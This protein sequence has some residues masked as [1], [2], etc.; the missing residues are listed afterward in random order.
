MLINLCNRPNFT[1]KLDVR[2]SQPLNV[3]FIEGTL[4]FGKHIDTSAGLL[5]NLLR[6]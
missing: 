6:Q 4:R 3:A 5:T 2:I 1:T